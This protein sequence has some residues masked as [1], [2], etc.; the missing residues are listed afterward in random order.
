MQN[1]FQST[2]STNVQ[3]N[4]SHGGHEMF[5]AHEVLSSII[6]VLDHYLM[7]DQYVK[8]PELKNILQHQRTFINDV[9]NI[10][11]QAFSTG[12]DPTHPTQSYK[13]KQ[14]NDVIYGLKPGQP[15]KPS[16]SV[17]EMN[18]Q[19]ISSFML[20]QVKSTASLLTM[21]AL[22]V[23]NPV[24]RRVFADSVPNF[25]EMGYELFQYQNKHAYY[26]VPQLSP[27]DMTQMLQSYTTSQQTM[28]TAT[29]SNQPLQ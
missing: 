8:D 16:T 23:T 19:S 21:S 29:A 2:T 25:I 4:V 7:Y 17:N 24:L 6:G 14:N 20:G 18:D 1:Q 28:N 11:V 9:Y 15:K 22:E 12:E 26:Q 27:Q 5:D 13:M 3:P 10:S